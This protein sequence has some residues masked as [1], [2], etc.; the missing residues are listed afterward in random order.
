[1]RDW[2]RV[3]P[4]V[5]AKVRAVDDRRVALLHAIFR[6]RGEGE[7]SAFIRARI[8]YFHQVG[9]YALHIQE[10]AEERLAL[11]PTYMSLLLAP[12]APRPRR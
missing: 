11:L 8:V 12:A 10:S 3:S 4:E 5:E 1:M 7:P 9:Y 2:A 6:R